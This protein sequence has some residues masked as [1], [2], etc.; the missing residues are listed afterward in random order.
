[1]PVLAFLKTRLSVHSV[2]DK[3]SVSD[4]AFPSKS[5]QGCSCIQDE[6][7]WPDGDGLTRLSQNDLPFP[8]AFGD[9]AGSWA[10][11]TNDWNAVYEVS[12]RHDLVLSNCTALMSDVTN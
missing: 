4:Y 10:A 2:Q 8:Y 12:F 9:N 6:F 1:M 3:K 11:L 7:F 5:L